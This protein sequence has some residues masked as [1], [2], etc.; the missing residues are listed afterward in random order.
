MSAERAPR[1]DRGPREP[2]EPAEH[3]APLGRR[4]R[5][6]RRLIAAFVVFQLVVPL[7]YYLRADR[8]DERFAWRM[9]SAVRLH[10]CQPVAS[11]E[12]DGD[13]ERIELGQ[14]I[15]QAW[16]NTMARNRED[17]IRAFLERRCE[18]DDEQ[19]A[20]DDRRRVI[21]ANHCRTASGRRLPPL[22][23]ER[24]CE[25]GAEILPDP[26]ALDEDRDR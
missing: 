3:D 16:I 15:H 22:V 23:Y 11:E 7:T 5:R 26:S 10:S 18:G 6:I 20:A 2:V 25:T 1:A 21:L 8:Y 19:D 14:V 24:Q 4:R 13:E 12:V 17:V 9:F